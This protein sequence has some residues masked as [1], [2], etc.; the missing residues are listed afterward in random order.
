VT[1]WRET[2]AGACD[3]EASVLAHALAA[4]EDAHAV[5]EN[6]RRDQPCSELRGTASL[7][8]GEQ[9][10]IEREAQALRASPAGGGGFP[11]SITTR[12]PRRLP[13]LT[14]EQPR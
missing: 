12:H 13:A 2:R 1:A 8:R 4:L 9:A 3:A 5:L 11:L 6:R 7:L 10:A 14:K